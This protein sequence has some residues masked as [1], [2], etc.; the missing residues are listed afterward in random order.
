M[1]VWYHKLL[2]CRAGTRTDRLWPRW[3]NDPLPQY[4]SVFSI[5]SYVEHV[6]IARQLKF[7]LRKLSRW[8][9]GVFAPWG[10][11]FQFAGW[12]GVRWKEPT[13]AN[14]HRP[15]PGGTEMIFCSGDSS[16]RGSL[17]GSEV[18]YSCLHIRGETPLQRRSEMNNPKGICRASPIRQN[19]FFSLFQENCL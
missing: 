5:P 4:P 10:W 12:G 13:W 8:H 1:T 18:K 2:N 6:T 11:A 7:Y 14:Q 17:R 9:K 15:Y 19:N 16:L 3:R